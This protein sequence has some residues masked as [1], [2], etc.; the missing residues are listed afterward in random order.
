MVILCIGCGTVPIRTKAAYHSLS[1]SEGD[2]N[3]QVGMLRYIGTCCRCTLEDL[4]KTTNGCSTPITASH[5]SCSKSCIG[6]QRGTILGRLGCVYDEIVIM[7][8]LTDTIIRPVGGTLQIFQC[9]ALCC[10]IVLIAQRLVCYSH[11][12]PLLV[13]AR[14]F[15]SRGVHRLD[16]L[17]RGPEER[18]DDT[19][20]HAC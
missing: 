15:R 9:S 18:F 12:R 11:A 7:V 2:W 14:D 1:I 3:W 6:S 10:L 4:I 20:F 16:L 5:V 19:N 8:I 17:P 13:D